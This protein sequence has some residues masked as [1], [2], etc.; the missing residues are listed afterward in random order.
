ME[1]ITEAVSVLHEKDVKDNRTPLQTSPTCP[2]QAV[3]PLV[4]LPDTTQTDPNLPIRQA[5]EM[6]H[7]QGTMS[8]PSNHSKQKGLS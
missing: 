3:R 1:Q 2:S 7:G 8:R 6:V 4:P 5:L